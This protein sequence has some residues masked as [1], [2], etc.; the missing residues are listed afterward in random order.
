M[1]KV[2]RVNLQ[3]CCPRKDA[4]WSWQIKHQQG[5]IPWTLLSFLAAYS[6][7]ILFMD[8]PSSW[9]QSSVSQLQMQGYGGIYA[10]LKKQQPCPPA[11]GKLIKLN[12]VKDLPFCHLCNDSVGKEESG[13]SPGA[14]Y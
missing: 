9:Q 11:S 2:A 3:C 8:I 10:M 7:N 5:K 12:I 1:E 4:E 14:S 6:G 13:L